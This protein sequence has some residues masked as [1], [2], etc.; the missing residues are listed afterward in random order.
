MY[1]KIKKQN[2]ENFAR[3]INDDDNGIFDI[4]NLDKIVKYAGKDAE[5]ILEY[6]SFLKGSQIFDTGIVEDPFELL[7]K[8]GYIAFHAD[9]LEKQNSVKKYI[10]PTEAFC[11]FRDKRRYLKFHI[12]YCI[13]K[14]ID[15]IKRAKVPKREDPYGLSLLYIRIPIGGNSIRITCRYNSAVKNSDNTLNSNPDNIAF[16]LSNALRHYFNV[17]FASKEVIL[18]D[19]FKLFK[20]Q[21]IKYQ[22]KF[23]HLY[24]GNNFYYKENSKIVNLN[25]DYEINFG[26]FVFNSKYRK[27]INIQKNED[28]FPEY[29][30]SAIK[31]KKIQIKKGANNTKIILLDNVEFLTFRDTALLSINLDN[32]PYIKD[33]FLYGCKTLQTINLK[34]TVSVGKNFLSGATNLIKLNAPKLETVGQAFCSSADK[35]EK[36]NIPNVSSI[37]RGSFA[38]NKELCNPNKLKSDMQNKTLQIN[39]ILNGLIESKN[40]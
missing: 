32:E 10:L 38:Y 33:N 19:G 16:G 3:T 26:Y 6:L 9:T 4:K 30:E 36:I 18:P 15:E 22:Q 5:P 14:N 28:S 24:V 35:I 29:F 8:A 23:R 1:N 13:K 12:V 17:D 27:L 39:N 20:G 25:P 31:N 7:D 37:G 11:T 21:I 34:D 40:K 2:G